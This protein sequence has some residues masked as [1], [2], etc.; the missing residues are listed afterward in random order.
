MEPGQTD[1]VGGGG[2]R[3]DEAGLT[4]FTGTKAGRQANS[5]DLGKPAVTENLSFAFL[6]RSAR[7][8]N[9][10]LDAEKEKKN[11]RERRWSYFTMMIDGKPERG[12]SDADAYEPNSQC[13]LKRTYPPHLARSNEA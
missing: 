1:T 10:N 8:P 2:G 6:H 13:L 11:R 12:L 5:G 4:E 7:S 9:S 3:C